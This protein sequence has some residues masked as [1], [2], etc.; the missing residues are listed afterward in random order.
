MMSMRIRWSPGFRSG[1]NLPETAEIEWAGR[2]GHPSS[3]GLLGGRRTSGDAQ[4]AVT[5]D[6]TPTYKGSLA[7]RSDKVL[8]ALPAEYERAVINVL[9]Q[10]PVPVVVTDAAHGEVGSSEY[11][12]HTLAAMLGHVMAAGVPADDDDVWLLLDR[13]W[14]DR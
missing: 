2:V 10:Q 4:V 6:G 14:S 9:R 8:W 13:C 5:Y 12:F 3:Y 11:V 1:S 7:G